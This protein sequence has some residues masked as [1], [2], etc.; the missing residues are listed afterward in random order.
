VDQTRSLPLKKRSSC[1]VWWEDSRGWRGE[2]RAKG[3]KT[4]EDGQ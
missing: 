3:E 1:R 4:E 2:D